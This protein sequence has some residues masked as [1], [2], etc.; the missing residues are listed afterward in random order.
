[1][2]N[3]IRLLISFKRNKHVLFDLNNKFKNIIKNGVEPQY[4]IENL[5]IICIINYYLKRIIKNIN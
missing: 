2:F 5:Y 4:K 1:M 3:Y